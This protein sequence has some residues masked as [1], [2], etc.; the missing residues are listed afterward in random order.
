[1]YEARLTGLANEHH[2]P[3]EKPMPQQRRGPGRRAYDSKQKLVAAASALLAERG[4]EATSPKMILDRAGIGQGS[5]Y[6]HYEGKEALAFDAIS[7]L[8]DRSLAYLEGRAASASAGRVEEL[9]DVQDGGEE[10]SVVLARIEATLDQLFTRTEG[11][12]LIR[13]LADPTV[14]VIKT[15]STA[16]ESWCDD[17]RTA[18]LAALD[19]GN[20]TDPE[21]ARAASAI[22]APEIDGLTH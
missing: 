15:L 7:H 14:A 13:L 18:I 10:T 21:V 22:L 19:G 5:L 3:T 6:H 1:M 12:A 8:R 17:L 2:T 20:T 9:G 11:R 4:Y 16:T